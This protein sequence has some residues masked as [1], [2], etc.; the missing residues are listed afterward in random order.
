MIHIIEPTVRNFSHEKLNESFIFLIRK[1]F[2]HENIVFF[3]EK[4]H[5]NQIK[6]SLRIDEISI[7]NLKFKR[8]FLNILPGYFSFFFYIFYYYFFFKRNKIEKLIFLSFDNYLILAINFL[9]KKIFKNK[10]NLKF[11]LHGNIEGIDQSYKNYENLHYSKISNYHLLKLKK[12]TFVSIK[13]KIF[14]AIKKIIDFFFIINYVDKIINIKTV[15]NI[16]DRNKIIFISLS[17]HATK[18]LKKNKFTKKYK[19]IKLN[20]PFILNDNKFR[21]RT[22]N[23][24]FK[25]AVYGH[26]DLILINNLVYLLNNSKINNKYMFK[27]IS[28][29]RNVIFKNENL[30]FPKTIPMTRIEM[31]ELARDIDFFI[32]LYDKN[33]YRYT[34]SA[35]IIESLRLAKPIIHI[36]NN[37]INSFNTSKLPI[38]VN[39][40]NLNHMCSEIVFI[41]NN[42]KKYK[43]NIN[44]FQNNIEILNKKLSLNNSINTMKKI[45]LS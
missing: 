29:N 42:Y 19:I 33:K 5:I 16:L 39:C 3:A 35:T 30:I 10:L 17:S 20:F 7:K 14:S 9:F 27:I 43:K 24:F 12:F 8:I 13:N 15:L 18:A 22:N 1:S 38:G 4:N 28:M 6:K 25:F 11:V 37:C 31:D 36:N 26:S 23:K 40:K 45:I 44:F 41:I 34:C 2:P 32:I 21:K